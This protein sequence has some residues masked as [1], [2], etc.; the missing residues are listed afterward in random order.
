MEENQAEP[1]G[2]VFA[3]GRKV[4]HFHTQPCHQNRQLAPF[5][6]LRVLW[7]RITGKQTTIADMM[8]SKEGMKQ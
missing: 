4:P 1:R 5:L 6:F 2:S 7:P 8:N 3:V